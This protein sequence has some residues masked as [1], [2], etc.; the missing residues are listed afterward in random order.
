MLRPDAPPLT[1]R[2]ALVRPRAS[3]TPPAVTEFIDLARRMDCAFLAQLVSDHRLE[4]DEAREV[5]V[6]LA[7]RLAKKAY[8]L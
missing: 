1:A 7:Y 6:D 5:A 8:R 3:Y 4:E 2:M